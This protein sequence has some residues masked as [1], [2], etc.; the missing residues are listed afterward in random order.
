MK[1]IHLV[2]LS[3]L[4]SNIISI[5]QECNAPSDQLTF[6]TANSEVIITSGELQFNDLENS[7]PGYE[8]IAGNGVHSLYA[9]NTWIGGLNGSAQLRL[10]AGTY[11]LNGTDFYSGP[12]TTDGSAQAIEGNCEAYDQ[13]V[14]ICEYQSLRHLEYFNCLSDPNCSL[15]E[16]FPSGY[17]IPEA[18][19]SYPAEGNS[20][21]NEEQYLAPFYDLDQDGI[22]APEQG[23]CPLFSSMLEES[24]CLSC[25]ALNGHCATF[26]ITNDRAGLHAE[27]GGDPIGIEIH[28]SI[29]GF[30]ST[31]EAISNSIFYQKKILNRSTDD[32]I[33]DPYIGLWADVDL[34]NPMDDFVQYDID[35]KLGFVYNG[36]PADEQSP[37]SMGYGETPPTF[38][39]VQ[40]S[41]IYVPETEILWEQNAFISLG[42]EVNS[43]Q[44]SVE[45]Y[46]ILTGNP[47]GL[48]WPCNN[49]ETTS[50]MFA[51]ETYPNDCDNWTEETAGNNPGDRQFVL[52]T[53]L[54]QFG[55]GDEYCIT[56]GTIHSESISNE[57]SINDLLTRSDE[58][59]NAFDQ[60]FDCVPPKA[61]IE[62]ELID[63][64]TFT[65]HNVATADSYLWDFGNGNTTEFAY[66]TEDFE[67]LGTY[68]ITL[69]ITNE[70]GSDTDTLELS[71]QALS[72]DEELSNFSVFP[73]P[74][75][76][77]VEIN[78]IAAD[79]QIIQL[80][81]MSG[82]LVKKEILN[83]NLKVI[84][85]ISDLATGSYIIELIDREGT[86]FKNTKLLKQ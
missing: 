42:N 51:G 24:D 40:L 61:E 77:I 25:E 38:G 39:L 20:T 36:D 81:D 41:P 13:V 70:C 82:R 35:R 31:D 79:A 80:I 34:G 3:I 26:F 21:A 53:G 75:G 55:F 58:I 59:Q 57:S 16:F 27:S 12:L 78:S 6:S 45:F 46:N 15:D 43:P 65:F 71:F 64:L 37:F 10:A 19:Y 54:P 60:C 7:L 50:Y 72:I 63:D 30:S 17:T 68:E 11:N 66:P 2:L 85:D 9:L 5:A 74:A 47:T 62:L 44:N 73:N 28:N 67:A 33:I 8:T 49:G 1:N 48:E 76:E 23:D 22:Y 69:T 84:L 14:E 4:C 52:S 18:F 29:Y 56:Y 32:L 86:V 83:S